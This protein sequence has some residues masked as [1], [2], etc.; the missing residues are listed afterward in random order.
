MNRPLVALVN[1][2]QTPYRLAL[3]RRIAC[4]LAEVSIA[5]VFTHEVS[6]APWAFEAPE[7]INPVAF[8]SGQASGDAAHPRH[9]LREWRKGGRIVAWLREAG[10]RAVVLGGYGDVGRLRLLA[11]CRRNGVP[12]LLW[13]DSNVRGD[14]ARG[15][16]R[17]VKQLFVSQVVGACDAVL[18]CGSLG[19]DYFARYGARPERSFYFPYEP[20]YAL[21][22]QLPHAQVELA[23]ARFGLAPGRRRLVFCGRLVPEK[24]CDLAIDTF[25]AI[26]GERP[27][28][29][30]VI[31]GGGPL[32]TFLE[33]RVPEQLRERVRW[34]GFLAD[35]AAV[36]AI[37]RASD[38][39]VMPSD[40]EPW[41]LVVNEAVAAGLAIVSTDVVGA[42]AELVRDGLNGRVVPPGDARALTA[43]LLDVTR[44]ERLA[45]MKAAAPGM[46]A[47]WRERGDPVEGLR[48]A[49]RA[50]G[51]LA[52][53]EPAFPSSVA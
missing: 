9:V 53:A 24:R 18:P 46:L 35:Q 34:T 2:A 22:R 5:S 32:R 51:V 45:V 41:G 15:L 36:S 13:G 11:W 27:G 23:R 14:R 31:A 19:A 33:Q 3:H 6:N 48:R 21:V 38:V 40:V 30:L 52:P 47:A 26:A 50:C 16:K 49:L 28:W 43:A 1:N 12:C 25:A 44:P 17:L 10:V 42:A 8:G 4:E 20:D 37:Y 29:D 7:D 39:L